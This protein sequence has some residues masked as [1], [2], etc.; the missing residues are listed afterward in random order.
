MMEKQEVKR[1]KDERYAT[2]FITQPTRHSH[3]RH[4]KR[5]VQRRG[6]RKPAPV[7]EKLVKR[8]EFRYRRSSAAKAV[9]KYVSPDS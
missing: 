9:K 6:G 4:L 2:R 7:R 5:A 1:V 3:P 8:A